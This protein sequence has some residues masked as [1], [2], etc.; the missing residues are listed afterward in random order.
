LNQREKRKK[1]SPKLHKIWVHSSLVERFSDK[2][3]VHGSIPC[4]PTTEIIAIKIF[5]SEGRRKDLVTAEEITIQTQITTLA[6]YIRGYLD[7]EFAE[8]F[9]QMD[10][11]GNLDTIDTVYDTSGNRLGILTA[12]RVIRPQSREYS[13]AFQPEEDPK[14]ISESVRLL[15]SRFPGGAT[16]RY[17][18]SLLL[19][20]GEFSEPQRNGPDAMAAI[21]KF[22]LKVG[23]MLGVS[24][25][26]T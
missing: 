6:T 5:M 14:I 26:N 3:E 10:E 24:P 23:E 2:E 15:I 4:A 13:L 1:C 7:G 12:E 17:E 25:K 19:N 18:H 21:K 16:S 20:G 9:D 11:S 22:G 8:V